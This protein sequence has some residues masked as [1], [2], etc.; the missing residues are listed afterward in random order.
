MSGLRIIHCATDMLAQ[1]LSGSMYPYSSDLPRDEDGRPDFE[2]VGILQ[3]D[4]SKR[5]KTV[6][7]ICRSPQWEA[8][9]EGAA[10]PELTV[11]FTN[12]HTTGIAVPMADEVLQG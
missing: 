5:P 4:L 7:L 3:T 11:T 1:M 8:P 9:A 10:I 2:V 12:H 6:D